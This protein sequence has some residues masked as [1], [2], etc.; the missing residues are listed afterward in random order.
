[1]GCHC[2]HI[3]C[4]LEIGPESLRIS[5]PVLYLVPVPS[6][7]M[8]D[9]TREHS[10]RSTFLVQSLASGMLLLGSQEPKSTLF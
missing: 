3:R 7:T 4:M 2:Q 8:R 6:I 10:E 5:S 9:T 1:M